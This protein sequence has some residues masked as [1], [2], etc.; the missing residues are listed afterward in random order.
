IGL[1]TSTAFQLEFGPFLPA[2]EV[3]FKIENVSEGREIEFAFW[4]LDGNDGRLS[5]RSDETDIVIFLEQDDGGGQLL[6]WEMR[7]NYNEQ[8]ENPNSGDVLDI[9]LIKPFLAQDVFQF[10]ATEGFIDRQLAQNSLDR[11][12]VVPNPYR[13]AATWE[14]RNPF[15]SGR[16][17]QRIHF[18][19][20]PNRCTIRIFTVSGELVDTIEH[21][22]LIDDGTAIWDL[23]SQDQLSISYGIYIYHV[24]APDVGETVGKFAIIK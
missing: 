5:A 13:V 15:T 11:I 21:E 4:E 17:P 1:A 23:L 20:L 8:F 16:G 19:H 6:T 12:Q 2:K 24:E 14:P 10:T 7:L 9:F 18:N 22:S 3:N